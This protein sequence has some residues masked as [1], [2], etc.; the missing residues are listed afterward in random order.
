MGTWV[1]INAGWYKRSAGTYRLNL[2][3]HR[4]SGLWLWPVLFVLALTSVAFNLNTEVFRPIL[5]TFLST[6]PTIWDRPV[7]ID[8]PLAR[9]DW[10]NAARIAREE[11]AKRGWPA[12]SVQ[13]IVFARAQGF[14]Q[15]R[16][17]QAH[18]PGFGNPSVNVASDSGHVLSID[19]PGKGL[20]C[21]ATS[22]VIGQR[23]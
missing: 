13:R 4:A 12:Q 20:A 2:D 3:L 15:V 6:S 22:P 19:E 9:I 1:V 23:H 8:P 18:A 21:S 11:A 10:D 16:L 17:G 14:Y 5:T 7:P